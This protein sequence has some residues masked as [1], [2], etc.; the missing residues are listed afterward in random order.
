MHVQSCCIAN[1]NLL[2]FFA[3]LVLAVAIVVAYAPYC[4]LL[5]SRNFA[6]MVTWR[7]TSPLCRSSH[8]IHKRNLTHTSVYSSREHNPK[9]ADQYQIASIIFNYYLSLSSL[10]SCSTSTCAGCFLAEDLFGLFLFPPFSSSKNPAS[11]SSS[12]TNSSIFVD[13][14]DHPFSGVSIKMSKTSC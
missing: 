6:S 12:G 3:V 13:E 9:T 7:P 10:I 8:I 1:I 2:L 5:W 11:S 4:W 14:C